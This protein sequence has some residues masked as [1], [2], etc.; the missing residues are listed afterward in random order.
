MPH[1]KIIC[2]RPRL[3]KLLSGIASR[4]LTVVAATAGFGKTTAVRSYLARSRLRCAWVS[5]TSGGELVFWDKLCRAVSV[6]SPEKG[7]ELASI[8]LPK[9]DVQAARVVDLANG[10]TGGLFVLVIDDYQLLPDESRV[11]DLIKLIVLEEPRNFRLV[12]I[13]RSLPAVDPVTLTAKGLCAIVTSAELAFT[14]QETDCYLASRGLR[15]AGRAV[16]KICR[17]T[18]G[19][20][21]AI[22]LVSEGVRN[23]LA[24]GGEGGIDSLIEE[25]F[26]SAL[27]GESRAVLVRLS[28]LDSFT[29]EQAV[30]AARSEK[31][32]ALLAGLARQNA[33]TTVDAADRYSFHSLLRSHLAKKRSD[34]EYKETLLRSAAW[35]KENGFIREA[36]CAMLAAEKYEEILKELDRPRHPQRRFA[37]G[38]LV[39]VFF[40]A[41][42]GEKMCFRYPFSYLHL[43]FFSFIS[44]LGSYRAEA[45]RLLRIMEEHFAG[46][47][48]RR[49]RLVMGECCVASYF[50]DAGAYRREHLNRAKEYLAGETSELFR[51]DD[52]YTFSVPSLLYAL[53]KKPGDLD[54]VI[55]FLRDTTLEEISGGLGHGKDKLAAAEGAL[56]RLDLKAARTLAGQALLMAADAK[57]TS[58]AAAA[59]FALMR[60]DLYQGD[61]AAAALRL[62]DIREYPDRFGVSFDSFN[63]DSYADLTDAAAGYMAACLGMPERIPQ[64]LKTAKEHGGMMQNGFGFFSLIRAKA[65]LLTG[66]PADA[67]AVCGICERELSVTPSQLVR[68]QT[69]IVLAAAKS[70]LGDRKA[71]SEV[72]SAALAEAEEDGV[73]LP[74]AENANLIET[75]LSELC[76]ARPAKLRFLLRVAG[77]CRVYRTNLTTRKV[78]GGVLSMR[79]KEALRL[80][81]AGRT[82]AE[83]AG[84]MGIRPVTAKKHL[85]SAYRKLGAENR[86]AAVK[87]AES[88]GII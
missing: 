78:P 77:A 15:L 30:Y 51:L 72:L 6:F 11:N 36:L 86:L 80:A 73:V 76:A 9:S 38:S 54:K 4:P 60:A 12:L 53:C 26:F 63:R 70:A 22:F 29:G 67:E 42:D 43:I 88:L 16:A 34:P 47:D 2:E 82:H 17:D 41:L 37:S 87:A 27:D 52:P 48:S 81:A 8:S 75:P 3:D 45:A 83:V 84:L 1:K 19:W 23:G 44:G 56:L 20:I 69:M 39:G 46:D 31:A 25:N 50:G 18:G 28:S 68:L 21:S 7:A 49:A 59:S 61:Y 57:Q 40:A 55:E 64:L 32:A 62:E 85:I 10:V 58:V 79:E 35:L 74:F 14:P 66:R 13:S 33:F 71:A 65:A 5:L 24:A